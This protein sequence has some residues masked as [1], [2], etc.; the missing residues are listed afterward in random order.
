M[1]GISAPTFAGNVDM[2]KGFVWSRAVMFGSIVQIKVK[3]GR[4]VYNPLTKERCVI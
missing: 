4:I 3:N 2:K 1:Y